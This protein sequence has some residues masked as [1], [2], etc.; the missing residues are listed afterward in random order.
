MK[1]FVYGTLLNGMSRFDALLGADFL[2]LAFARGDLYDLGDFPGMVA[3]NGRVYGELY[4]IDDGILSELDQIEGYFP[5]REDHCTY[6]R[7]EIDVFSMKNG[8]PVKTYA[9]FYNRDLS[10]ARKIECGDYRRHCHESEYGDHWYIAY[11]SN[12]D[13]SRLRDRVGE[14]E[15]SRGGIH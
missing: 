1:C 5:G 4:E 13:S 3:G 8:Q 11:G 7:K 9:Y 10:K 6:L 2:G 12:M 14:P 15:K